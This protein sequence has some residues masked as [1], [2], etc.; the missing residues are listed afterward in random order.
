M[1]GKQNMKKSQLN[2][3]AKC[4]IVFCALLLMGGSTRMYADAPGPHPTYM[5]AIEYLRQ[6]R[7]VLDVHFSQSNLERARQEA[8]PKIDQAITNL[9]EAA[10]LD[11]K[12]VKEMPPPANLDE[13]GRF[14]QASQLLEMAK[15]NSEGAEADPHAKPLRDKAWKEID[16]ANA[17][18]RAQ[19]K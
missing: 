19:F 9:K 15:K 11:E 10:Q 18:I 8:M 13:K 5:H 17:V 3:I 12:K 2:G 6:A 14:H 16:E 4:T 7:N 1:K